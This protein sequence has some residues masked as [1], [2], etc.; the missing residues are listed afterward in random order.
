MHCLGLQKLTTQ[1][2]FTL[3]S[4]VQVK[5]LKRGANGMATVIIGIN[6]AITTLPQLSMPVGI[7]S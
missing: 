1:V 3:G 7:I 4:D 6:E 5:L 2:K